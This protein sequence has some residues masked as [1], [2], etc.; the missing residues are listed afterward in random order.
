MVIAFVVDLL[1]PQLFVAAILLD[2]PIVL[3][4]LTRSSRFTN[5]LVLAALAANVV[6][7]YVNGR[8]EHDHWDALGIGDRVLAGLSIVCV[9]YLSTAVQRTSERAGRL[10]AQQARAEREACLNAAIARMRSS[11][12]LDLVLHAVVREA[13][14]LF[15]ASAARFVSIERAAGVTLVARRGS[16]D[17]EVDGLRLAPEA[18]SLVQRTLDSGDVAP[19][20]SSDAFGRLVLDHLGAPGALA[21]PIADR[22]RRFGVLLV[23]LD[24]EA[25]GSDRLDLA[26]AYAGQAANA[27]A[28]ARLFDE[29]GRRN[30][31][32]EERSAVIRD[33]VYALSHDLRTPLAAL[34]MTMRQARAGAYGPLPPPYAEILDGSITATDDVA[35]LAE[36]LLLVA[37]FESGD[38]QPARVRVDLVALAR[39]IAAEL[40][41]LAHSRGVALR[42]D[43]AGEAAAIGDRDDLRRAVI[44]LVSNALEHSP[45]E[46]TVTIGVR[47]ASDTVDVSVADEGFGIPESA[48]GQLFMR[49][50]HGNGRSGA[51]T[52]LGLYIVRRVAQE[53]GG[54][55][56]YAPREGR[57][58]TFTI[59][60]P[61]ERSA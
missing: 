25:T 2:A 7:G 37:R 21:L 27:L 28:Q 59:T 35:R 43:A 17:I 26:R 36:T 9:G 8:S 4:S 15:D 47:C 53:M 22:E 12:S 20:A 57:G 54:N 61:R 34:G 32:L 51:G 58:S 14:A 41:A 50:A 42:V 29:L 44:N 16:G 3:S 31:A 6:A 10:E 55:V 1:T 40:A 23:L 46:T 30:R 11:L 52:G 5:I 13:I 33:L 48:R 19:I 45:A 60:L 38:R 24:S 18:A 49:F 39:Q 56:A